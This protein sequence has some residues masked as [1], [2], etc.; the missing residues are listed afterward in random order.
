MLKE[1]FQSF[2]PLHCL[3]FGLYKRQ[4][5]EEEMNTIALIQMEN[6]E[7]YLTGSLDPKY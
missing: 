3:F 7:K 1:K 6:T 4:L 5:A 2:G